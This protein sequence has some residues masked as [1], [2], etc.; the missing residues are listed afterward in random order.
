LWSTNLFGGAVYAPYDPGESDLV[1]L[2]NL[3]FAF[4][5][6]IVALLYPSRRYLG[7]FFALHMCVYLATYLVPILVNFPPDSLWFQILALLYVLSGNGLVVVY[8]AGVLLIALRDR[9]MPR[10]GRPGLWV[11]ATLT[12]FVGA[13]VLYWVIN[14]FPRN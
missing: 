7:V 5:F 3:V 12:G 1:Q 10:W 6:V 9:F 8:G 14:W 13:G 4:L 11:P 2:G